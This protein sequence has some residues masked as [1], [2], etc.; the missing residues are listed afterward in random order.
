VRPKIN[1]KVGRWETVVCKFKMLML[2]GY[3]DYSPAATDF[4]KSYQTLSGWECAAHVDAWRCK[5]SRYV[6]CT[7]SCNKV[8]RRVA[9]LLW[10]ALPSRTLLASSCFPPSQPQ[11]A[12]G[13]VELPLLSPALTLST[14][15]LSHCLGFSKRCKNTQLISLFTLL[16]TSTPFEMED[17]SIRYRRPAPFS[18]KMA[19][20]SPATFSMSISGRPC[21]A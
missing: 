1:D 8:E 2:V 21:I 13:F 5:Y 12:V 4:W 20:T 10:D 3:N 6:H 15:F 18:R 9:S 7:V 14:T 11:P 17:P 19:P 16:N